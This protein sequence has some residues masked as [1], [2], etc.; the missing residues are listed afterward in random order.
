[1]SEVTINGGSSL[2]NA[3]TELLSSQ[4]ILP[5]D[6]PSYQLCRTIY[7]YHPLGAKMAEAPISM[8]QSQQREI[9]IPNSP[10]DKVRDQFIK[11][12]RALQMDTNI[13]NVMK[14]SRIYGAASMSLLADGVPN[15]RPIDYK[16]LSSLK[17]AFNVL[18]PLNTSGSLV[19]NQDPNAMDFQKNTTG[20]KVS[21]QPYHPSR[22][23]VVLNE[24]PIY[25]GYTTSA[26]GYVGRSVYQR[27][28]FPLKSFVQTMLTD[29]MVTL[30]AGVLVAKLKPAGSIIDQA[31]AVL[32]GI[33]RIAIKI[34]TTGNVLSIN[35]PDEE[36][37]SLDLQ[38]L[39]GP[40]KL[41][42]GNILK[43]IAT[44]ADMP[45]VMLENETLTEGFGEGTEDA[46][47]IAK[48]I[49]RV[50]IDTQPC[51]DFADKIV[52]H[53]AWTPEFYTTIQGLYPD[54]YAGK[55]YTQAFYEWQNSFHAE[56]PSLLT[57]PDS[58]KIKVE[59]TKLKSIVEM[60]EVLATKI[61]PENRARLIEWAQDNFNENKM[62]FTSP[63]ELDFVA[64]A[65]WT[66]PTEMIG[67][68]GE[69]PGLPSPFSK[70][71]SAV[72]L[73]RYLRKRAQA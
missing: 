73:P 47:N 27:A 52:M 28:L 57:E 8:A 72:R 44:A 7:L 60:I 21:G 14:T 25:L 66:P 17:I 54:S 4:E 18:D 19:M 64:L 45:A 48:Y 32:T 58:E 29:D 63:L 38:N 53:R 35:A 55:G 5:G 68:D 16:A 49:D 10:E 61:D 26:F 11:E 70:A 20:I 23:V 3:L 65:N 6:A 37:Q 31:M 69:K 62:L 67:E 39:E 59:E 33:K 22:A 36:L 15:N 9:S 12:W 2:G 40:F 1:M 56:W 71:D 13:H 42:R 43:N 46:K 24:K 30:K 41:A 50:R 51:Y 34:A